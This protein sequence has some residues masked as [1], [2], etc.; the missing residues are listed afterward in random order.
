MRL[1]FGAD[2]LAGQKQ[3]LLKPQDRSDVMDTARG[4][5]GSTPKAPSPAADGLDAT[6]ASLM[7]DLGEES[8]AKPG[9]TKDDEQL[10][11]TA[12]LEDADH[13]ASGNR[14]CYPCVTV[15]NRRLQP[16][17]IRAA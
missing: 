6:L 3:P 8:G 12:G 7:T 11:E 5:A 1:R 16:R 4:G 14:V 15:N 13:L 9:W 10:R 17:L 2:S